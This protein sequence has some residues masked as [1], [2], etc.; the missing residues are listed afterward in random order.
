MVQI[1]LGVVLTGV[2]LYVSQFVAL[3]NIGTQ[4]LMAI[5]AAAILWALAFTAKQD[6]WVLLRHR[7]GK[8]FNKWELAATAFAASLAG[9]FFLHLVWRF[10]IPV[11]FVT[12]FCTIVWKSLKELAQK[13]YAEVKEK[14]LKAIEEYQKN[15]PVSVTDQIKTRLAASRT[16]S[17]DVQE[18]AYAEIVGDCEDY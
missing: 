7:D 1:I 6:Q 16:V 11:L 15:P 17:K 10:Q 8:L 2:L 5:F 9:I 18:E 12:V 13:K 4:F 3:A 14:R